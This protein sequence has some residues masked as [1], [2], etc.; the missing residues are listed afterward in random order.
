MGIHTKGPDATQTTYRWEH[1]GT[2]DVKIR[3]VRRKKDGALLRTE[4]VQVRQVKYLK[5][6]EKLR[7]RKQI[8]LRERDVLHYI[9]GGL[10]NK[11]IAH[12]M[13]VCEKTVKFHLT[14]IFRKTG[15]S[16]RSALIAYLNSR[17]G[18]GFR[19]IV[20]QPQLTAVKR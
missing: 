6:E 20:A 4:V 13:C 7:I 1:D 8:S 18:E 17:D 19:E 5:K 3:E 9:K 11:Q 16:N 12:L 15:F 10:Q 14:S 2:N